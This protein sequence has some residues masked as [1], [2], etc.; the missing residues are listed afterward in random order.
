MLNLLLDHLGVG[1]EERDV[2][3]HI[4]HDVLEPELLVRLHDLHGVR[5]HDE[6]T[7]LFNPRLLFLLL[8]GLARTSLLSRLFGNQ[9][10][11][12]RLGLV[13]QVDADGFVRLGKVWLPDCLLEDH[14]LRVAQLHHGTDERIY[15][16]IGPLEDLMYG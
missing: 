2:A 3:H 1:L 6:C 12:D 9:V 11:L 7:L 8:L 16:H 5:L 13:A 15:R 10:V 4:L 14:D